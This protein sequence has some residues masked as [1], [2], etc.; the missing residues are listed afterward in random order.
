MDKKGSVFG[1]VSF[2][3]VQKRIESIKQKTL[4]LQRFR[5]F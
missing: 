5:N 2:K 1:S 4:F 3:K